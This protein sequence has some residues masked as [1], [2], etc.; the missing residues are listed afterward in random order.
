MTTTI[1]SIF[2]VL[3]LSLFIMPCGYAMSEEPAK[4]W[5]LAWYEN[6]DPAS[7]ARDAVASGDKK[8]LAIA[9]RGINIPGIAPQ[10]TKK[11]RNKCGIKF[12]K[13]IGDVIRDKNDLRKHKLAKAYAKLYNHVVKQNCTIAE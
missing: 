11:Y 9:T 1:H 3:T 5:S 7:D 4:P 6:A 8:F 13:G 12:I 2:I 10:Q